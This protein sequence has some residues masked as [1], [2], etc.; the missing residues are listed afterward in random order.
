MHL[1]GGIPA[2]R[3]LD[4]DHGPVW[5]RRAHLLFDAH[6]ILPALAAQVVMGFGVFGLEV[7]VVLRVFVMLQLAFVMA[8]LLLV[9]LHGF[10]APP[11]IAA[12]A[13]AAVRER[14]RGDRQT[15]QEYRGRN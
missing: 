9:V 2:A 7:V 14:R 13:L 8:L 11:S 5:V 6:Q 1:A 4:D 10:G 12:L 3:S 15:P